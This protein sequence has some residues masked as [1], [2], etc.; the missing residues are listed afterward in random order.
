MS[1]ITFFLIVSLAG[2]ACACT[3]TYVAPP[4]PI[5][6]IGA[7]LVGY[8]GSCAE[9]RDGATSDGSPLDLFHCHG[10]P[11]QRWFVR[12]GAISESFGSC[13]DVDGGAAR[14]GASI[15]LVTC[16]SA[17]SQRWAITNG[18]VVGIGGMCLDVMGGAA[19]DFTPL[20]LAT[21][22]SPPSQSWTIQ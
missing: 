5:P 20:V 2:L 22:R 7:E 19:A 15:I 4:D 17:P 8:S 16:N 1:K 18:Q 6:T 11:N 10:S 12:K 3:S 14:E 9:V 13:I 21:C